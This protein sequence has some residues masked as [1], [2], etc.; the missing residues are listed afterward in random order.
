MENGIS[1]PGDAAFAAAREQSAADAEALRAAA[2]LSRVAEDA[3]A[4]GIVGIT[5]AQY[6]VLT[7]PHDS[8][9][10]RPIIAGG[11]GSADG[12]LSSEFTNGSAI[13]SSA[14]RQPQR[15]PGLL[16]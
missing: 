13:H 11:K 1:T 4:L 16:D 15:L 14:M 3:A 7:Y 6:N 9:V 5:G 8:Y 12:M 10:G 2:E